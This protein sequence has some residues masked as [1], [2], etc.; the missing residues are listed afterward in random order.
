M[1]PS[2]S[3]RER[4][5]LVVL[6]PDLHIHFIKVPSNGIPALPMVKVTFLVER[7]SV[8]EEWRS[9]TVDSG[10]QFV[11]TYG[12]EQIQELLADSLV[13]YTLGLVGTFYIY[14]L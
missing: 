2:V 11:M 3:I 5:S 7:I 12:T 8:K 10:E 6:Q 4:T 13:L 9:A 14:S 1:L